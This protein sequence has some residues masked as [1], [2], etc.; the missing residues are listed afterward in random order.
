VISPI[1]KAHTCDG[2]P[3]AYNNRIP[4]F[5]PDHN[6]WVLVVFR[7]S[8]NYNLLKIQYCPYCG[9]HLDGT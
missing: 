5:D 4:F 1:T 2:V 7:D 3:G 6:Q 8:V 9:V